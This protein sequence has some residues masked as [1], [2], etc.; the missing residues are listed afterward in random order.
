MEDSN[1]ECLN[2]ESATIGVQSGKLFF[3]ASK[4]AFLITFFRIL[5]ADGAYQFPTFKKNSVTPGMTLMFDTM[6]GDVDL[7]FS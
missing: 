2:G 4:S 3:H 5:L 1:G 7:Y 6:T